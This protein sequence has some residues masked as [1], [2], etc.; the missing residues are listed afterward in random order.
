MLAHGKMLKQSYGHD[1]YVVFIGPCTAKKIEAVSFQHEG[2]IDAVLTFEEPFKLVRDTQK[3]LLAQRVYYPNYGV[4][5]LQNILYVEK[6]NVILAI[7]GN[8]TNEEKQRDE[9][10]RVKE[11][12]IDAAEM[13]MLAAEKCVKDSLR[14]FEVDKLDLH[15]GFE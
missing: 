11:N 9:L 13:V 6:Q 2:P 10:K 4:V 14:V 1:S 8:I 15:R 7:M 5:L 12:A 3:S